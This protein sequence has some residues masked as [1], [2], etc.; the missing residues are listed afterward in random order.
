MDNPQPITH[1]ASHTTRFNAYET[2]SLAG[3][4]VSLNCGE[5]QQQDNYMK[6]TTWT[7]LISFEIFLES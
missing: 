5:K 2:Q 1:P 7:A 3:V 4:Q 6:R